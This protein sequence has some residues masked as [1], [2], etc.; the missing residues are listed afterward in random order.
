MNRDVH[1][2][3]ELN[4]SAVHV[5][6]LKVAADYSSLI[7]ETDS[8]FLLELTVCKC[9]HISFVP[10]AVLILLIHPVDFWENNSR[11]FRLSNQ[12]S[13][14]WKVP[15]IRRQWRKRQRKGICVRQKQTL[16]SSE[17]FAFAE[18]FICC[19][20]L[21][22]TN[23]ITFSICLHFISAQTRGWQSDKG[24][25]GKNGGK[26]NIDE[27]TSRPKAQREGDSHTPAPSAGFV[28]AQFK[29]SLHKLDPRDEGSEERA[30]T[31]C[32]SG[33]PLQSQRTVYVQCAALP[34]SIAPFHHFMF[35]ALHPRQFTCT[36][37]LESRAS[38]VAFCSLHP[39]W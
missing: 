39:L 2:Q 20:C 31:Y 32:P 13:F 10:P 9:Q 24:E 37:L 3:R 19:A 11:S 30:A 28:S 12:V 14:P 38:S 35:L 6:P 4:L 36:R 17:E 16:T 5:T 25:A 22:P 8:L 33:S 7:S 27:P 34:Y 21:C 18:A 23:L 29:S 15:Q 1:L 26:K